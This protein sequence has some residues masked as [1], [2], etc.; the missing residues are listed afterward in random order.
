MSWYSVS[1]TNIPQPSTI[2]GLQTT[3]S[4]PTLTFRSSPIFPNTDYVFGHKDFGELR[5]QIY[6]WLEQLAARKEAGKKLRIGITNNYKKI[7]KRDGETTVAVVGRVKVSGSW[8]KGGKQVEHIARAIKTCLVD[9]AWK[10]FPEE[11]VVKGDD[12]A[13]RK[14]GLKKA[15]YIYAIW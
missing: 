7:A 10:I 4:F 6:I 8:V 11:G 15:M 5:S 12:D 13:K 1:I 2:Q 14:A 3:T 9:A